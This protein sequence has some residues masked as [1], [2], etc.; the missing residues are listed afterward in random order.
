MPI[1]SPLGQQSVS[2]ALGG[3]I[4]ALGATLGIV[5]NDWYKDQRKLKADLAAEDRRL[6]HERRVLHYND[7]IKL[8]RELV[9]LYAMLGDNIVAIKSLIQASDQGAVNFRRP[10]HLPTDEAH[11]LKLADLKLAQML[12][13]LYYDIRRLNLD[14]QGIGRTLDELGELRLKAIMSP[15]IYKNHTTHIRSQMSGIVDFIEYLIAHRLR[16]ITAYVRLATNVDKTPDMI[17]R[18]NGIVASR[19]SSITDEAVKAEMKVVSR[20]GQEIMD[21]DVAEKAAWH[22]SQRQDQS[23]STD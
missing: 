8:N 15:E 18:S 9:L 20:E 13:D 7:L 17:K 11:F 21:A 6:A 16:E 1:L 14:S 23:S 3:L 22:A 10:V 12:S 4:G 19:K 2:S 5:I